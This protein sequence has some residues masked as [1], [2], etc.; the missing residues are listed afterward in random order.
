MSPLQFSASIYTEHIKRDRR[1]GGKCYSVFGSA[2]VQQIGG[3]SW[4]CTQRRRCLVS[5]YTIATI[6][7]IMLLLTPHSWQDQRR[8]YNRTMTADT[9]YQ[10][11]IPASGAIPK[12]WQDTTRPPCGCHRD[13]I[14]H[15]HQ[16]CIPPGG[17]WPPALPCGCPPAAS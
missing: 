17:P 12:R 15:T 3:M 16:R 5:V 1:N 7:T 8:E 10:Q 6:S 14:R 13:A 11:L 9:A 4:R 2:P